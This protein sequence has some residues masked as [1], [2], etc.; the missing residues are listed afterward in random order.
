MQR[1]RAQERHSIRICGAL[2]AAPSKNRSLCAA[3][4]TDVRAHIFDHPEHGHVNRAKHFDPAPHVFLRHQRGRGHD[5]GPIQ[6]GRLGQRQ[7]HIPGTRW[8]VDHQTIERCPCHAAHKLR[9]HFRQHGAAPDN[10]HA[11]ACDQSQRH[12]FDAMPLN[13]F[14]FALGRHLWLRFSAHH[15][16]HIRTVN[17]RIHQP[18]RMPHHRQSHSQISRCRGFAHPTLAAGDS[19][20]VFDARNGRAF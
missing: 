9:H 4:A 7:L 8:Q 18:H 16:R 15:N 6:W 13:G 14:N 20:N 5:Q 17:I 3:T 11:I 2:S 10:R 1:Y 19:N 12:Q